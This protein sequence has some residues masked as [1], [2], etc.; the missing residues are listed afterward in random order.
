MHLSSVTIHLVWSVVHRALCTWTVKLKPSLLNLL[1]LI[2]TAA[3]GVCTWSYSNL[4]QLI[5]FYFLLQE[6]LVYVE[7][8]CLFAM[9]ISSA[10]FQPCLHKLGTSRLYSVLLQ[11]L[12]NKHH[13][14]LVNW[15]SILISDTIMIYL[16]KNTGF[17]VLNSRLCPHISIVARSCF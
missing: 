14:L 2:R 1:Q 11:C 10:V 9:L 13:L 6:S 15:L 12:P 17:V 7:S 3:S 8:C 5:S 4:L 16:A